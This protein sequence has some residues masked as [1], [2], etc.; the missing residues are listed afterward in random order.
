MWF[1]SV[2][3]STL[4]PPTSD[5]LST[6]YHMNVVFTYNERYSYGSL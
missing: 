1:I 5:Y 4:E 6:Y 3:V 2:F